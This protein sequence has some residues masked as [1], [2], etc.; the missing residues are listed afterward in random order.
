MTS[1]PQPLSIFVSHAKEDAVFARRLT[2]SL[3]RAKIRVWLAET[4]LNVGD[5]I[6]EAIDTAIRRTDVLVAI[7]SRASRKAK[8]FQYEIENAQQKADV[9]IVVVCIDDTELPPDLAKYHC[10]RGSDADTFPYDE[11]INQLKERFPEAS[12]YEQPD[13]PIPHIPQMVGREEALLGL[14][15]M[16]AQQRFI[17]ITG[18]GGIGKTTL[19]AAFARWAQDTNL[20]ERVLWLNGSHLNPEGLAGELHRSLKLSSPFVSIEEAGYQ[21]STALRSTSAL[22]VLDDA[23]DQ[24]LAFMLR[25]LRESDH[26][27]LRMLVTTRTQNLAGASRDFVV[28]NLDTLSQSEAMTFLRELL[29]DGAEISDANAREIVDETGGHPLALRM[30]AGHLKSGSSADEIVQTLRSSLTEPGSGNTISETLDYTFNALSDDERE[31]LSAVAQFGDTPITI[32]T[33][34]TLSG[35]ADSSDLLP[36][37]QELARH[38]VIRFDEDRI[39]MHPL[40]REHLHQIGASDQ[41]TEHHTLYITIDPA[42]MAKDDFVEVL[43]TLNALYTQLG[44]D[45]LIIRE[46]EIGR[47]TKA[48][49]LV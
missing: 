41:S 2:Q 30:I 12:D 22:I 10:I 19:A 27:E 6:V 49:V 14:E 42:L 17:T 45:E 18:M 38:A 16:A 15:D 11:L 24:S 21:I 28:F 26:G 43:E 29:Q 7:L 23:S 39:S 47:F 20:V 37:V 25:L 31:V 1:E 44:G 9:E 46:D 4:A 40:V 32:R 3:D 48:G 36:V 33:L 13:D 5:S 35:V 8:W 34:S